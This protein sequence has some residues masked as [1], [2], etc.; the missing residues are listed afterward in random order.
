LLSCAN[1]RQV[2][3]C[4][5]SVN[6]WKVARISNE[7]EKKGSSLMLVRIC[8]Q[9]QLLKFS[10]CCMARWSIVASNQPLSLMLASTIGKLP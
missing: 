7:A 1:I 3:D 5:K 2:G 4:G 10:K 6:G 8:S 9:N